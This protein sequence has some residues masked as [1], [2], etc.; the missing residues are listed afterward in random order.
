[1]RSGL[2]TTALL[3]FA[4]PA[5]AQAPSVTPP[6]G[7]ALPGVTSP[8]TPTPGAPGGMPGATPGATPGTTMGGA[9]GVPSSGSGAG[10][11]LGGSSGAP[12]T[13]TGATGVGGTSSSPMGDLKTEIECKNP[14]NAAKPECIKQMM[15]K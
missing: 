8:T 9:G 2:L 10:G 7:G 15:P 3:L 5:L 12:A 1:M 14:A 13:G 4:V 6:K 11:A